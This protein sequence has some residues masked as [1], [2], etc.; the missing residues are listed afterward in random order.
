MK[1]V[2]VLGAG[3]WGTA[4][5]KLLAENGAQVMLWAYEKEVALDLKNEKENKRYLAGI[6]L[7]ENVIPVMSLHEAVADA[8]IIFEAI[9]VPHL[10]AVLVELK[11]VI[12]PFQRWVVLSKGIE[13]ISCAL[14]STII[15]EIFGQNSHIA[16]VSGPSFA[17]EVCQHHMTGVVVASKNESLLHELKALLENDYF[18]TFFSHDTNGVQVCSA[19]KN[20]VT[21]GIG[22][23]DGAGYADNTKAFFM[24]QVFHEIKVLMGI[25]K[26]DAIHNT[27]ES[28]AGI[29]DFILTAFGKSSKNLAFG[30]LLGQG[31]SVDD[32]YKKLGCMPE[33]IATL[34]TIVQL[35]EK[36]KKNLPLFII[37]H[38]IIYCKYSIQTL[39]D[40]LIYD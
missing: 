19:L 34:S 10:K 21:L 40:I 1:K 18:K 16:V 17:R 37:L 11:D 13:Q 15:E 24:T 8:L 20:V 36:E 23:L 28:L 14:P 6:K 12:K 25:Y 32:A 29:G 30:K 35:L 7:P 4:I 22:I 38:K 3:A 33:G 5:A 2:A 31:S 27:L 9:P 39:L 26:S